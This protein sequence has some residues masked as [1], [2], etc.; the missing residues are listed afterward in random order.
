MRGGEDFPSPRPDGHPEGVHVS[1]GPRVLGTHVGVGPRLSL[2]H[3][4]LGPFP[5]EAGVIRWGRG[6]GAEEVG[7]TRA[8]GY[9]SCNL[10]P[11]VS[12]QAQPQMCRPPDLEGLM[13]PG[14]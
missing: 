5:T 10:P 1:D 7:D 2:L 4:L 6:V 9:L 14:L 13:A 3:R 11:S 8:W 12:A